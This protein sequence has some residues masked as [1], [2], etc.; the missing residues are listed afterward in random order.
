MVTDERVIQAFYSVSPLKL[1]VMHI[2]TLGLYDLYWF[3]KHW[4]YVKRYE[5]SR[6]IPLARAIL[7]P[8]FCYALLK[9]VQVTANSIPFCESIR[10]F[11]LTTGWITFL[12]VT[13][14]LPYPYTWF[15]LFSVLF[16]L[17]VQIVANGVNNALCPGCDANKEFIDEEKHLGMDEKKH[18]GLGI[19][20]FII[21][22]VSSILMFVVFSIGAYLDVSTPGGIS[23]ESTEA[24]L[25]G[26]FTFFLIG[27]LLVAFGLGIGALFQKNRN[28]I[29]AILGVLISV[30]TTVGT[31]AI[32]ILGAAMEGT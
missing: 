20:S 15:H 25:I 11:L 16:L 22:I 32:M 5:D 12:I 31:V 23:E 2:C 14:Y 6:I 29:F 24:V 13:F 7:A 28:K 19:A 27:A 4:S 8:W 17:P 1:F 10:P 9:R 21:S 26:L 3:Y 18:S 30:I